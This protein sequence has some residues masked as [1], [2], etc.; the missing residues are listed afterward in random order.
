MSDIELLFARP[1]SLQTAAV[2]VHSMIIHAYCGFARP[3]YIADRVRTIG[4][5]DVVD[6]LRVGNEQF[7]VILAVPGQWIFIAYFF[8]DL[9]FHHAFIAA[10]ELHASRRLRD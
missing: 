2:N 1:S 6:V 4:D 8:G 5:I 7:V 10:D 3:N 9:V